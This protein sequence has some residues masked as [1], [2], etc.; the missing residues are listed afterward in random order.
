M[1]GVFACKAPWTGNFLK[2]STRIGGPPEQ[3]SSLSVRPSV[4]PGQKRDVFTTFLMRRPLS[5]NVGFGSKWD[6]FCDR[7]CLKVIYPQGHL[8]L[9]NMSFLHFWRSGGSV[10]IRWLRCQKRCFSLGKSTFSDMCQITDRPHVSTRWKTNVFW[11][12]KRHVLRGFWHMSENVCFPTF[13][14]VWPISDLTH[15]K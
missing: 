3:D 4:R 15:V 8:P 2:S 1:K 13:S 5:D 7:Q 11:H 9:V 14:D 12:V 6:M 10:I